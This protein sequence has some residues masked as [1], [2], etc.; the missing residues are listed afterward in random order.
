VSVPLIPARLTT[1]Y[2]IGVV[3]MIWLIAR[4]NSFG[5]DQ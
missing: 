4:L 2:L 5:L 3:S 1:A